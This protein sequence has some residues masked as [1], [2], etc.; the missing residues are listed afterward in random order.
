MF[1]KLTIGLVLI[2]LFILFDAWYVLEG[3]NKWPFKRGLT[4]KQ[5]IRMWKEAAEHNGRK[6]MKYHDKYMTM[7]EE[8]DVLW[9]VLFANGYTRKRKKE[10]S[11]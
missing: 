5:Q 4:Q 3:Q 11:H 9:S 1:E 6:A 7:R 10:A 2:V 8:V